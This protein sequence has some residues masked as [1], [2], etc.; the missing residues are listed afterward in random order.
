MAMAPPN[1]LMDL[2]FREDEDEDNDDKTP[3]P[4]TP[5]PPKLPPERENQTVP[6][7]SEIPQRNYSMPHPTTIH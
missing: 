4:S 2:T 1:D 6:Q 7:A 5:H 3:V